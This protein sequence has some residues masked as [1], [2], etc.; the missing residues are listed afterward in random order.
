MKLNQ[1]YLQV[2]YKMFESVRVI[3]R[4]IRCKSSCCNR[5]P[6]EESEPPTRE[7]S[8]E[9]KPIPI[10]ITTPLNTPRDSPPNY[11]LTK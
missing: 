6:E 4:G 7:A 5:I 8:I 3:I 10:H 9:T 2:I 1:Y 11:S